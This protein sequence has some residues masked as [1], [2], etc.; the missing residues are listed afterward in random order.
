MKGSHVCKMDTTKKVVLIVLPLLV[1]VLS[2][3]IWFSATAVDRTDGS[4][5]FTFILNWMLGL[6]ALEWEIYRRPISFAQIHWLFFLVFLV[7]APWSQYLSDYRCWG[8][9]ATSDSLLYANWLLFGWGIVFLVV[10]VFPQSILYRMWRRVAQPLSKG[11]Y[12]PIIKSEQRKSLDFSY[13]IFSY[14]ALLLCSTICFVLLCAMAG[15][16]NLFSK[17]T[18]GLDGN[19]TQQLIVG[20]VFRAIPLFVFLFTVLG[21]KNSHV[22]RWMVVYASVLLLLTNFPTSLARVVAAATFGGLVLI[23]LPQLRKKNGL[24]ILVLLVGLLVVF[25]AINVFRKE[26][27]NLG[28]AL[29]SVQEA[30]LGIPKGFNY[31]DFDAFSMFM[32]ALDYVRDYGSTHG[33]EL[34]SSILFFVPRALWPGKLYGSGTTIGEA[35]HLP[36]TRLST[37]LPGEGVMNF[38]VIGVFL[39]AI[40]TAAICR[41]LDSRYHH[42]VTDGL[43][44]FYPFALIFFFVIMRGELMSALSVT[45]GYAVVYVLLLFM[46]SKIDHVISIVKEKSFKAER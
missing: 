17:A 43:H 35:A 6:C 11:K 41:Y 42:G 15:F 4:V 22:K 1:A 18:V 8:Y 20:V 12:L 44:F 9:H 36:W 19:N 25:P 29:T 16:H 24:F 30:I 39:F 21:Y 27:L 32:R 28:V 31:E 5:L 45:V 10:S 34:L 38:G 26:T 46:A 3:S 37:P 23:F 2:I 7:I 33:L 13:S 14:I 40:F